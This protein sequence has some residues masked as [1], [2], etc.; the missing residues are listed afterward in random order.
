[1]KILTEFVDLLIKI[2][3]KE[4]D[5]SSKVEFEDFIVENLSVELQQNDHRR[6][7]FLYEIIRKTNQ[8]HKRIYF[9]EIL[10]LYE[11]SNEQILTSIDSLCTDL[12]KTELKENFQLFFKDLVYNVYLKLFDY[13]DQ[14]YIISLDRLKITDK[15]QNYV[16]VTRLINEFFNNIDYKSDFEIFLEKSTLFFNYLQKQCPIM[17]SGLNN[18]ENLSNEISKIL[19][20]LKTSC[21]IF[22]RCSLRKVMSNDNLTNFDQYKDEIIL[23]KIKEQTF[24]I[25]Y[26]HLQDNQIDSFILTQIKHKE[27]FEL[28]NEIDSFIEDKIELEKYNQLYSII[29]TRG[30]SIPILRRSIPGPGIGLES[31]E[32]F[33]LGIVSIGIEIFSIIYRQMYLS[34]LGILGFFSVFCIDG[35]SDKT[36]S[37]YGVLGNAEDPSDFTLDQYGNLYIVEKIADRIRRINIKDCAT[38]IIVENGVGT[39]VPLKLP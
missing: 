4:F 39:G 5:F 32:K 22:D 18:V 14:I 27:L 8:I 36:Q 7:Q 23:R 16:E 20:E 19:N 6:N 24:E 13:I 37:Y 15:Y 35:D 28:L 26:Q 17:A 1:M 12:N 3:K 9:N 11:K 2:A 30:L 31:I 10:I 29:Q 25:L 38:E 21:T 33:R 34:V